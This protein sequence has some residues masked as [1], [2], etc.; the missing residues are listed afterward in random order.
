MEESAEI[1]VC[2]Q[3]VV[4]QGKELLHETELESF[5]LTRPKLEVD[6]V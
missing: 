1:R 3:L 5:T 6:V 2:D 4:L